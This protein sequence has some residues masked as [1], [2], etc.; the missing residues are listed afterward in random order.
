MN[1]FTVIVSGDKLGIEFRDQV[2]RVEIDVVVGMNRK[3]GCIVR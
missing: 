2:E 3:R 1:T